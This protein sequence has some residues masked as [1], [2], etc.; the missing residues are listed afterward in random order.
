MLAHSA[1]LTAQTWLWA[2]K[3]TILDSLASSNTTNLTRDSHNN[4]YLLTNYYKDTTLLLGGIAITC[5]NNPNV[6]LAKYDANGSLIWAKGTYA[7]TAVSYGLTCDKDDNVYI[8]GIFGGDS[9]TFASYTLTNVI[10]SDTINFNYFLLKID[11]NGNVIYGRNGSG[12]IYQ[13][14]WVKTDDQNNLY[15]AGGYTTNTISFGSHTLANS[16]PAPFTTTSDMFLVKYDV[17]GNVIWARSTGGY[18]DEIP[19]GILIHPNGG[20]YIAGLFLSDTMSLSPAVKLANTD[21]GNSS[22][23]LAKYDTAGNILWVKRVVS[24]YA[25]DFTGNVAGFMV[26]V[27][28]DLIA[29]KYG[30]IYLTGFFSV[31][32]VIG[33]H[34]YSPAFSPFVPNYDGYV[35]KFDALGNSLWE[36]SISGAG[37]DAA[38]RLANDPTNGHVW[39]SGG[40]MSGSL[41]IGNDTLR[42]IDTNE[43][44][45]FL[46]EYDSAGNVHCIGNLQGGGNNLVTIAVDSSGYI[47]FDGNF[48]HELFIVGAD[49]LVNSLAGENFYIAKFRPCGVIDEVQELHDIPE[50]KLFPNPAHNTLTIVCSQSALNNGNVYICNSIGQLVYYT[51]LQTNATN[52]SVGWF[53]PGLYIC[54]LQVNDQIIVKKIVVE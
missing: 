45:V 42:N 26:G 18:S 20:V 35:A 51:D 7:T 43:N 44:N 54:R 40:F 50:V 46:A 15:F 9:L 39:V 4:T 10:P 5:G 49:T 2:R 6:L 29:D 22:A 31:P 28:N 30:D 27:V 12:D 33:S 16:T 23:F 3:A 21:S 34:S 41:Y 25:N 47:Y 32:V 24:A 37:P 14:N 19:A 52:V 17:N 13:F 1:R 36:H 48:G 11:P 8:S 38:Y 53:S